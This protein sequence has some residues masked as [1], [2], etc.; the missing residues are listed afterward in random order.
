M[1]LKTKILKNIKNIKR[2]LIISL[3]FLSINVM[4]QERVK[5]DGVAVVVGNNIVLDSDIDKFKMEIEMQSQGKVKLSNCEMMEEIM[6][7]KLLAHH[8]VVD[9]IQISEGRVAEQVERQVSA[10]AQQL[11]TMDKVVEFYG[12]NDEDD[13]RKELAEIQREQMLINGE[14]ES[15]TENIAVTPDEV[16]TYFNN[17][18][19]AGN[20][21]EFGA[22][23]EISQIVIYAKPTEEEIKR[24]KDKLTK[25]KQEIEDG[26]S[27]NMKAIL[28]SDDPAASGS[29]AGAGGLYT[30]SR[31]SPFVKEFKEVAFSLDEGQVSEPFKTDFGYHIIKVEKI[32]GQQVSLRHILMQPEIDD[33]KLLD[34]K[35]TLEK[36]VEQV[37]KGT[38]SFEDAVLEYSEEKATKYNK[39]VIINPVTR[40]SRF[41]LTRMDPTLYSR[42]SGLKQG[43]T[44]DPFYE[45]TREGEKMFKVILLKSKT[46]AHTADYI[47]DYVKIQSL[48]LQKKKEE[49]VEKWA[50]EKIADTYI[51]INEG[52]KDCEFSKNWKKD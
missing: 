1:Q 17:L 52:Y 25:L 33:K 48:A 6:T 34:A 43:E 3:V 39:G 20:L 11:G 22:E 24:V 40:D 42:V 45:E 31:E 15:I 16:R 14:R 21:P 46:D 26:S 38:I 13:L 5:V 35:Q 8:A 23:I 29:G 50:K 30:I 47:N 32:K 44:T 12:F 28:Y 10:F 27:M 2:A 4:A 9:S 37:K 41:E 18:K 7:Q 36:L 19:D 49:E 51:K